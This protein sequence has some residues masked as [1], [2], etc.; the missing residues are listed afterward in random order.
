MVL[1]AAVALAIFVALAGVA[2]AATITY[3]GDGTGLYNQL[4]YPNNNPPS[5]ILYPG[6]NMSPLASGNSI[7]INYDP[8]TGTPTNP[9]RVFGGLSDNANVSGNIVT[10]TNGK[11][12]HATPNLSSIWGGFTSGSQN[13]P[14]N[15][16]NNT[17]N[18]NGGYV[19]YSIFGG[20]AEWGEASDNSVAISDGIVNHAAVGGLSRYG[21]AFENSIV[22]T[23]GEVKVTLFGGEAIPSVSDANELPQDISLGNADGNT[24][25]VSGG[26]VHKSV[27]AGLSKFGDSTG[28]TVNISGGTF[29]E[30][31]GSEIDAGQAESDSVDNK[32]FISG[33]TIKGSAVY[34]GYSYSGSVANSASA[35]H[36]ATNN[37]VTISGSPTFQGGSLSGGAGSGNNMIQGNKVILGGTPIFNNNVNV[38]GG[39]ADGSNSTISNNNVEITGTLNITGT[40]NIYGGGGTTTS[41][42]FANNTVDI[43]GKFY[44]G[45]VNLYGRPNNSTGNGNTLKIGTAGGVSVNEAKN[46]NTYEFDVSPLEDGDTALTVNSAVDLT[47]ATIKIDA[48]N[49]NAKEAG[50]S[51]KITLISSINNW[52]GGEPTIT[53]QDKELRSTKWTIKAEGSALIAELSEQGLFDE[54][55]LKSVG[56]VTVSSISGAGSKTNP[57][58]TSVNVANSKTSIT[59]SD[60]VPIDTNATV[61]LY[62][63]D[64][65]GTPDEVLSFT[66]TAGATTDIY[67][68]IEADNGD[69]DY[70]AVS[71]YRA[72]GGG[73]TGTGG[74]DNSGGG[75]GT[76]TDTGTDSDTGTGNTGDDTGSNATEV[77]APPAVVQLPADSVTVDA[78][79]NTATVA[80]QEGIV[81][82]SIQEAI[83][84]A[85]EAGSNAQPTVEINVKTE[86]ASGVDAVKV[87]IFISDLSAVADSEVENVRVVTGVGE[88]MLN[89]AA[90]KDL[91][92]DAGSSA[93]TVELAIEHKA[94]E[95][96]SL[97]TGQKAALGDA[98][99]REVYDVSLYVDSAKLNNFNTGGALTIG[100]PYTLKSGETASGVWANY[101]SDN[102]AMQHM[103]EGRAYERG[104]AIFKTDH[105]SVYAVTYER[106]GDTNGNTSSSSGSSGGGCDALGGSFA[107]L[108]LAAAVLSIKKRGMK[109]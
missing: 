70:Y 31:S 65:F 74:S 49:F 72:A 63:D 104:L 7:T 15:A 41:N 76:D 103:E 30:T 94:P 106:S 18:V 26:T 91:I 28:N 39:L 95:D 107:V 105:L 75:T 43:S 10:L 85:A 36:D 67:F 23:G 53:T 13:V 38:Y 80:V 1:L 102:G 55:G 46:F 88:V 35:S 78:A 3:T 59:K 16:T 96:S 56:G 27:I 52:S 6:T 62:G 34:G 45:T 109:N 47:G 48:N 33:G 61:Y 92:A 79:T 9:T 22:M 64:G 20:D 21:D 101:V 51:Y 89:T 100:L 24:V 54:T 82:D 25:T 44:G 58:A 87:D 32:V 84:L 83:D 12:Y 98:K 42:T 50:S 99:V 93:Q 8:N 40:I 71:V 60:I 68:E 4:S 5:G 73:G 66:L 37:T 81:A 29:G 77:V 108:T 14:T 90:I 69:Y 2:W 97:S 19:E 11:I 17:V 86:T 57:Y